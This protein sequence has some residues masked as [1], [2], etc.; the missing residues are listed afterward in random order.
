MARKQQSQRAGVLQEHAVA[1]KQQLQRLGVLQE[2]SSGEE[3]PVAAPRSVAGALLE[4]CWS[5]AE[6]QKQQ[7]AQQ[8]WKEQL[9]ERERYVAGALQK[10]DFFAFVLRFFFFSRGMSCSK[11][12]AEA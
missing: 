12:V 1:K 6:A 5:A 9:Q 8:Q 2:R 3:V 11:V 10:H 7:Q 4:R